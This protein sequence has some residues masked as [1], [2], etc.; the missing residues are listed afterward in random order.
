MVEDCNRVFPDHSE[1][2]FF[3]TTWYLGHRPENMKAKQ[4]STTS[5][6]SY[7]SLFSPFVSRPQSQLTFRSAADVRVAT[8]SYYYL[9]TVARTEN[10]YIDI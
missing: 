9:E 1:G 2:R 5:A 4:K 3:W 7:I 8:R 10:P 6:T